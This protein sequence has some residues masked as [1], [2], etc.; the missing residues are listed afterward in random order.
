MVLPLV[1]GYCEAGKCGSR[2]RDEELGDRFGRVAFFSLSRP[3][4][5]PGWVYQDYAGVGDEELVSVDHLA[6]AGVG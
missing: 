1:E 6:D 4:E 5:E 2:R 3:V